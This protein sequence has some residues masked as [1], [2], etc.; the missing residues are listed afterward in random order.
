M[1]LFS[2]LFGGGKSERVEAPTIP[3]FEIDAKSTQ[4]A[5]KLLDVGMGQLNQ[6]ANLTNQAIN[7]L[8]QLGEAPK[9]GQFEQEELAVAQ[10][11]YGNMLELLRINSLNDTARTL[12]GQSSAMG[13]AGGYFGGSGTRAMGAAITAA[14]QKGLNEY[15][16]NAAEKLLGLRANLL[17]GVY[18]RLVNKFEATTGLQG[19]L[20]GQATSLVN[21]GLNFNFAVANAK[22]AVNAAQANLNSQAQVANQQAAAQKDAN[23]TALF[24][25][26]ISGVSSVA[27]KFIGGK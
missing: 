24:S 20:Q 25:S 21:T 11:T 18:Q 7:L 17:S 13:L 23:R 9:L 19:Q 15:G 4:S 5:N 12:Q 3:Q 2:K 14:N 27:G 26:I 22:S 10:Q 16:A 6:S 1:G 8:P